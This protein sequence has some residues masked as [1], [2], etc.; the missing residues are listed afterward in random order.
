MES[1][2]N[3][4][5]DKDEEDRIGQGNL[6]G[7][8]LG[9]GGLNKAERAMKNLQADNKAPQIPTVKLLKGNK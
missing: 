1:N 2:L 4:R 5:A 8:N 7:K 9:I 3:K 6:V